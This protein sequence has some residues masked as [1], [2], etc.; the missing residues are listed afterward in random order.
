M[1][2]LGSWKTLGRDF[3]ILA[4]MSALVALKSETRTEDSIARAEQPLI[5]IASSSKRGG[6]G[7][8]GRCQCRCAPDPNPG[9][10]STSDEQGPKVITCTVM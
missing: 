4:V 3:E 8:C 10:D 1:H 9:G 2:F 6:C 5:K 7:C